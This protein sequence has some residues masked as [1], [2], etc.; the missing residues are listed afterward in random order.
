MD[1]KKDI[2]KDEYQ[3]ELKRI[4]LVSE[5]LSAFI[6]DVVKLYPSDKTRKLKAVCDLITDIIEDNS[7]PNVTD[8]DKVEQIY[9]IT[10]EYVVSK[11]PNNREVENSFNLDDVLNPKGKLDLMELCKE[12]GVTD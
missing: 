3:T 1:N 7:I 5:N 11:K 9:L 6:S 12:L 4:A 2:L 8:K 10:N